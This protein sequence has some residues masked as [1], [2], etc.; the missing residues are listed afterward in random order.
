M[1]RKPVKFSLAVC[2]V[3]CFSFSLV[4]CKSTP[5]AGR[6][7]R[8]LFVGNS[9]T[10]KNDLPGL[11]AGL[12][13]ARG[14][15]VQYDMYAPGGYTLGRHAGDPR[16]QEKINK[17]NW[18]YVV[19][20]EQ[21]RLPAYPWAQEEVFPY[22]EKL[23]RLIRDANPRAQVVFYETMAERNGDQRRAQDFPGL[24]TYEGLQLKINEAYERLSLENHGVLVPV[25]EVWRKVR[26]RRPSLELYADDVHPNLAGTYL[27]A[28]VFYLVLFKDDPAGLPHP[29]ELDDDTAA[30]LQAAAAQAL[31]AGV[32]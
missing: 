27:A 29:G 6:E 32:K 10:Y 24:A 4:S 30:Y 18:D 20:Q 31:P 16:L 19:L 13:V 7:V 1:R 21:S 22:A 3:L 15:K 12:A 14:F 26:A 8:V 11:T 17:G 9:L 23:S 25:G 2:A 5:G 28:C